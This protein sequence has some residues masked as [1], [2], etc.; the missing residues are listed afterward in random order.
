MTAGIRLPV[1]RSPM[2]LSPTPSTPT[3]DRSA[4]AP[5]AV[6]WTDRLEGATA[7]D[8]LIRAVKPLADALGAAPQRRKPLPGPWL[9]H[10]LPPPMTDVPIGFWTSAVVLDL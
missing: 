1:A 8:P 5:A 6:T 2:S 7:L 4:G 3:S 10:A 9:G